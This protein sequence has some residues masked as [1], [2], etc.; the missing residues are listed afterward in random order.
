M[1]RVFDGF[2]RRTGLIK[3]P[4]QRNVISRVASVLAN[5]AFAFTFMGTLGI[6]TS[7]ILAAAG[8]TGATIGFACRDYGANIV[9]GVALV[10]QP[11]FRTG[12]KVTIGIGANKVDGVIDHWDIRYLY[13][14]GQHGELIQVPNNF[15]LNSVITLEKPKLEDIEATW[16]NATCTPVPAEDTALAA[17]I[18]TEPNSIEGAQAEAAIAEA[19]T[20]KSSE[21]L[22]WAKAAEKH[23]SKTGSSKK[24]DAPPPTT[25]A[26]E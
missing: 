26:R 24:A 5:G 14:K 3:D 20:T 16:E 15:V 6:D 8:I 13:L 21:D 12:K 19:A 18:E 17:Q 1:K 4:S 23:C 9:A 22:I 2:F 10:G 11:C 25:E 7:P